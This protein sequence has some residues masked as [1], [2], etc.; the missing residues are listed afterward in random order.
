M[1][2]W[3]LFFCVL[4]I[5]G[6]G[7]DDSGTDNPVDTFDRKE[8]LTFWADEIIIPGLSD[9]VEKTTALEAA[10]TEFASTSDDNQ[11]NEVRSRWEEAYRSW[12]RISM[13]EIGKA[14]ELFVR[15]SL[16]IYPADIAG[17]EENIANG[18][19]NLELPSQIDRQGFPALDYLLYGVADS[20]VA[21][22]NLYN[23]TGA[24]PYHD[25]LLDL[26]SR[27]N[28]L[29]STVLNDWTNGYRETFIDN[30]GNTAN[31]S[32]DKM[33]NDYIFY[34]E[35]FLRAGKVGIPAGV[36]SGSPL[37]DLVEAPYRND[38]SRDLLLEALD[39]VQDF[40]NGAA[41]DGVTKGTSLIDYL[42]DL[43]AQKDGQLLSLVINDQF[44]AARNKILALDTSFT[45]QVNSNNTAMLEAYDALQLNVVNIKVD[46]LQALNISVDYV[47]ADGD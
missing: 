42:D 20:E 25:Y 32:T 41:Y 14:E 19:Y 16:N 3:S 17:I 47:D 35:R 11:L 43:D 31:A 15:N 28:N 6:C 21:I 30:S 9:F 5:L 13:F 4:F 29:A 18:N 2:R 44:D 1:K 8:M 40:F 24:A 10:I 33:V 36:F 38:L 27:I 7:D 46:L 22:L 26:T 39:A 45:A 23:T 12:Q 34:Y 37:A